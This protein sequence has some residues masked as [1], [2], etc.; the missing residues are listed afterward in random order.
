MNC[1]KAGRCTL[2]DDD[3]NCL[4]PYPADKNGCSLFDPKYYEGLH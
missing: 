3:G 4:L 2:A 1:N